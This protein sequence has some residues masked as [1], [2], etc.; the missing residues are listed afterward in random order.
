MNFSCTC[1]AT[2]AF[3]Y[4]QL[5]LVGM[6][7][8]KVDCFFLGVVVPVSF[9]NLDH[10]AIFLCVD[11]VAC[12]NTISTTWAWE[13]GQAIDFFCFFQGHSKGVW[14]SVTSPLSMPE[15]IWIIVK[16]LFNSAFSRV[17]WKLLTACGC[18]NLIIW[19]QARIYKWFVWQLCAMQDSFE[20]TDTFK[21]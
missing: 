13:I 3:Q 11:F 14:R 21:R 19:N 18:C 6:H 17:S 4:F 20:T 1:K 8:R 10:L 5:N 12:H 16:G 7:R 9:W 2:N 15:G